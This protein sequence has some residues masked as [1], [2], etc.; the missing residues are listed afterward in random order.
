MSVITIPQA[1]IIVGSQIEGRSFFRSRLLGTSNAAYV[2]KKTCILTFQ[3]SLSPFQNVT[4]NVVGSV[5]LKTK[6]KGETNSQTPIILRPSH[7]QILGQPLDLRIP[8]I[9]SIQETQQV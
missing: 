8:Y 2:K 6:E 4:K 5:E 9:P 3:V 7:I 1:T